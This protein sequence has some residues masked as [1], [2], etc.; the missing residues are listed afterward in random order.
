[1]LAWQPQTQVQWTQGTGGMMP[2]SLLHPQVILPFQWKGRVGEQQVVLLLAFVVNVVT[3][4]IIP[5]KY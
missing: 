4:T 5:S 3:M 1:M 2:T